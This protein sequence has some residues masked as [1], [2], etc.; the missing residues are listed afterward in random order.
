MTAIT[1]IDH[2]CPRHSNTAPDIRS[3]AVDIIKWAGLEQK[4]RDASTHEAGMSF[5]NSDGSPIATLHTTGRTDLQTITSE[6]E[7]FRGALA[8]IFIS[9][10]LDR[11]T[12][13]YDETVSS[14][15]QHPNSVTVTFSKSQ[16]TESYDLLVGAEGLSSP[17]RGQML[18]AP[19]SSQIYPE[20]THIAYFT[21]PRDLLQGSK[22]AKGH[23]STGGRCACLR[24]DPSP[25]GATRAMLFTTTWSNNTSA[26]ARLNTA[27]HAS[28][29]AYKNLMDELFA[30]A[31]W[32]APEIL[33]GMREST[34]FYCSQMAQTRSPKLQDGRVV[35]LGDAGYAL[36]GLGTSLAITGAYILAGEM[37]RSQGD[38]GV[39]TRRY[40][41]LMLPFVQRQQ[42]GDLQCA[43]QLANPQTWWGIGVRN[44]V[45]RVII[46]SGLV[47]LGMR[48]SAWLGF[49]EAK[50]EMPDYPWPA[51]KVD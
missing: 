1:G 22:I 4:I 16:N 15:S 10:I 9:P 44:A 50:V 27:L 14:Y 8:N 26:R 2:H 18:N 21:I 34:D 25:S 47:S 36:P 46:G 19:P 5:V 30:D 39:A 48:V 29:E 11:V 23:N 40:E 49:S 41:E 24:P 12:I 42:S 20:G 7:I 17:I 6:Y 33:K 32:L 31:G 3:N 51:E 38:V 35:L 37:L 13:L 45:L 28:D 43:M